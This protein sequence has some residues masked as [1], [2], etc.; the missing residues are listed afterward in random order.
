MTGPSAYVRKAKVASLCMDVALVLRRLAIS[1][2][3]VYVIGRF[4]SVLHVGFWFCA[5]ISAGLYALGNLLAVYILRFFRRLENEEYSSCMMEALR[6]AKVGNLRRGE[7][8]TLTGILSLTVG[9]AF[10]VVTFTGGSPFTITSS[11]AWGAMWLGGGVG[12][13]SGRGYGIELFIASM[14]IAMVEIGDWWLNASAWDRRQLLVPLL[15]IVAFG[16]WAIA[17]VWN[18]RRRF[19]WRGKWLRW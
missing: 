1:V 16:A 7:S 15:L 9:T 4:W 14:A 6:T 13:L 11:L 18:C 5:G 10:F 2:W 12:I 8:V 17:E 3:A 19:S